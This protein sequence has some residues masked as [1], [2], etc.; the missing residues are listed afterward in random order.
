MIENLVKTVLE[1]LR[2]L[3]NTETVVGKPITAGNQ[4][5]IPV[6]KISVGFGAGGGKA[7]EKEDGGSGMGGGA[8]IDPVAFIVV[9]DDRTQIL[10]LVGKD[11]M[12]GKIIDLV[13][14]VMNRFSNAKKNKAE[15]H[16]E[17]DSSTEHDEKEQA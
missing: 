6:A 14:D 17:H 9:S 8:Q 13:P 11:V 2:A 4:T 7:H 1:E 10:P 3:V 12:W 5:I 15:K 16:Q